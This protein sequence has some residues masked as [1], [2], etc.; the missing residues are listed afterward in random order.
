MNTITPHVYNQ[1]LALLTDL[2]QLT[3]SYGY[4]K[5]G[6]DT[7]E[8]V[9]HLFF[10]KKPFGGGYTIAAGLEYVIDYLQNFRFDETDLVYLGTLNG[11]D[12]EPLFS[13]DFL[14][15]LLNLKFTCDVD[16][17]PEGTVVFPY[18][19]LLRV[20]GP[21][22]QAQLLE[23]PILN[24]INFASL[25]ATKAARVCYAAQNDPVLEFGLRRA[26]GID[27]AMTASRSAYIGGCEST[28]NVL[29]GKLFGIPVRGTHS[30]SWVMIF[31]EEIDSF[32]AFAKALPGNCIFLVDTYNS[33]EGVKKAIEVGKWLDKQ[34][35]RML[36]IRLDSG[37]L[38]YLSKVSRKMLDEA[39]FPDAKIV[40][41]N[42]LDEILISDLKKQGATIAI[43]GVGTNLVTAKD[44]PAL[45]G[46][47]KLSAVRDPDQ[48]WQYRLKLS[49]QM[50]KISNPGIL[51]IRRYYNEK[52]NIADAIYDVNADLSKGCYILDPLD[53]TRHKQILENTEFRDLLEPIFRDG[54]LVYKR[55]TLHDI[56]DNAKKELAH[57]HDGIKRFF[58]PHQY[59]VGMEKS[60]YDQKLELI[61]HIRNRFSK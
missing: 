31:D 3:M 51:Q 10:R 56:R 49:E 12:G 29:A 53:P 11:A 42:E 15:Y 27:G 34:G 16:A 28:S 60:L 54:Q 61:S 24:Q 40:A 45:D 33:I 43:W 58:N 13:K 32:K 1:S 19:P 14:D 22:I 38:A 41:S 17:V 35:K 46:V 36:G 20:K 2:Y 5:N 25:I 55:P 48:K 23:T 30:H 39:G 47:Y 57:F 52:E 7:K 37:D 26:Q 59:A 9:F 44:Q 6:L 50:T 8:A 18:E 4:W 21:L